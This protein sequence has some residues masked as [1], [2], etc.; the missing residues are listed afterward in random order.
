MFEHEKQILLSGMPLDEA[1]CAMLLLHGRGSSSNDILEIVTH[2]NVKE[3]ALIAP[4]ATY[5]IWYPKSFLA[6]REQNQPALSSALSII[7]HAIAEI[8]QAGIPTNNIFL[9]GFSQGACLAL[10]YAALNAEKYAG[11]IALTGG[12]IGEEVKKENYKGNFKGTKVFIGAGDH[13]PHVPLIR[14]QQT[15][16]IL[17][18]M[19][20]K[21]TEKIYPN[22]PHGISE[23]EISD[24]NK[25]FF[26]S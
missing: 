12:L 24:V 20:A 6:S 13:D 5:N 26:T 17:K 3:F 21:V 15:T 22:L 10:E 18:S 16:A 2:L 9:L 1:K 7:K 19:N 23:Q 11:I 14:V 25:L 4:E 8:N